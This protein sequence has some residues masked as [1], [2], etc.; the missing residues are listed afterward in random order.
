MEKTGRTIGVYLWPNM[1]ML[2][3]LGPHQF[4]AYVPG[5]KVVTF[6]K[7]KDPVVTDTGVRL[8][9]DHD[10][11]T[12]P[13][14]DILLVGGGVNPLPEMQDEDALS[15]L[16][17]AADGAEY[18]TSVCT[19][20]LILAEAGLLKG[21][22]ATAHWAYKELLGLYPDV[23]VAPG[24]VVTDRNR[25]TSVGVTAGIDL[26]LTLIAQVAGPEAAAGLQ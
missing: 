26:G 15:F 3:V 2:D 14:L 23:E 24:R 8:I 13:P 17:Q 9:P 7:T 10:F 11:S 1:T 16:R 19:G 21:Y 12:C 4:L 5:F 6:A 25:I 22:R 20:S 18:V